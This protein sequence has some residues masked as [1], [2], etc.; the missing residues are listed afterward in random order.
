MQVST[1]NGGTRELISSGMVFPH[2]LAM[3]NE[4]S[5]P[6][7]LICPNDKSITEASQFMSDLTDTKISYFLNVD[8]FEEAPTGVLC[9]DR[10]LS[11]KASTDSRFIN[12]TNTS[13]IGW[14]KETHS[15]KGY[16]VFADASVWRV[17][18]GS[19]GTVLK[20]PEG[21]TNRL[22]IP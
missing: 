1:N 10:N 6:K 9:G 4:L 21:V 13:T 16:L 7:I 11:N 20:I 22:A 17:A 15:E 3:S 5:T 18:N 12:V 8:A 19:T 14:T 2:F